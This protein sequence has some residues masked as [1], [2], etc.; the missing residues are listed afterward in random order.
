MRKDPKLLG[1]F[2]LGSAEAPH[3]SA[4]YTGKLRQGQESASDCRHS[5]GAATG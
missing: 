5:F 1:P 2:G 3:R 4:K